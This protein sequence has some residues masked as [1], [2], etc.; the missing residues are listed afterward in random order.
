MRMLKVRD[1]SRTPGARRIAEGPFSAELFRRDHLLPA[2]REA[3]AAGEPL[4]VVLD[5]VAGYGAAFLDEAFA[6][7]VLHEGLA[8]E[9]VLSALRLVSEEEPYLTGDINGYVQDTRTSR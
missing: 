5:G 8:A 1:F 3:I 9:D 4:E 6:G 7:L 2:V